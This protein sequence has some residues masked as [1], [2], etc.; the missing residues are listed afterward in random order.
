LLDLIAEVIGGWALWRMD[1]LTPG[2][3]RVLAAVFATVGAAAAAIF[4][5]G[6]VLLLR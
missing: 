1:R 3:L 5:V 2:A 6:L 4:V